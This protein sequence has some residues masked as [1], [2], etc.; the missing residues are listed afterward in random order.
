MRF[1]VASLRHMSICARIVVAVSFKKVDDAPTAKARA[2]GDNDDF[3]RVDCGCE[4]CHNMLCR[5]NRGSVLH[6]PPLS[7]FGV[8]FQKYFGAGCASAY[9]PV[10]ER[11]RCCTVITS[12]HNEKA[13]RLNRSGGG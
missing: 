1:G 3:E 9:L 5:Q 8:T 12:C 13:R 11:M 4:K 10:G 7:D 6:S 2:D